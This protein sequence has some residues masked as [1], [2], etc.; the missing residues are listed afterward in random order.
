[1][2]E[3]AVKGRR[4]NCLVRHHFCPAAKRLVGRQDYGASF[5]AG[6]DHLEEQVPFKVWFQGQVV[7]TYFAD[8]VVEGRGLVEVKSVSTLNDSMVAQLLNYMRIAFI[9][10]GYLVNFRNQR[11]EV[12]RYVL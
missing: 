1:M 5:I 12:K 11:L 10:V 9:R 2:V 6:V 8:I 4:G 7:G 3:K